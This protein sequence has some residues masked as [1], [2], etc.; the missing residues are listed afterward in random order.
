MTRATTLHDEF[1]NSAEV[2]V[3]EYVALSL[4]STT[5]WA[6]IRV[7]GGPSAYAVADRIADDVFCG[8]CAPMPEEIPGTY[9]AHARLG[10]LELPGGH[11]LIA[12]RTSM[13]WVDGVDVTFDG[14]MVQANP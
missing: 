7:A 11:M 13:R 1:G 10:R 9:G 4:M 6:R 2:T 14:V 5:E 12:H 3:L 8:R